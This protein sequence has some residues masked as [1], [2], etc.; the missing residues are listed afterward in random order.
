MLSLTEETRYRD[1]PMFIR[2]AGNIAGNSN[3]KSAGV[4][5]AN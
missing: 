5:C 3:R 4:N 1:Y 2:D